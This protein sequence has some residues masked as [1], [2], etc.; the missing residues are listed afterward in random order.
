M[1]ILMKV[2]NF[3]A[4]RGLLVCLAYLSIAKILV[5]DAFSIA[6]MLRTTGTGLRYNNLLHTW[7]SIV[8]KPIVI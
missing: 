3:L 5:V 8:F 4:K 7:V 1:Y 6:A 2:C